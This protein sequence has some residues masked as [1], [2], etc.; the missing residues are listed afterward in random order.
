M[1]TEYRIALHA[2]TASGFETLAEFYIGHDRRAAHQLFNTLKGSPDTIENGILFMELRE[3]ARGLPL[4]IRMVHCTLD[5]VTENCRL[6][7]KNQ[8]K[9]INLNEL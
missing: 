1:N 3:I 8:F 7:T 2:R 4:D 6:I 5:E 9:A